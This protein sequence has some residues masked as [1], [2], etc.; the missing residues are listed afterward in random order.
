LSAV[1]QRRFLTDI[2]GSSLYG[3]ATQYYQVSGGTT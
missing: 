1:A 2:G 3:V